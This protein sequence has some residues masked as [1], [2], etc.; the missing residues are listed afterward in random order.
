[1]FDLWV[2]AK[3]HFAAHGQYQKQLEEINT[4]ECTQLGLSLQD[5]NLRYIISTEII[6]LPTVSGSLITAW[7]AASPGLR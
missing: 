1:M 7:D 4:T 3:C 2:I 5:L 6:L